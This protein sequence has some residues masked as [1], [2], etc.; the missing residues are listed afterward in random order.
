[1]KKN[2]LAV[3]TC[4]LTVLLASCGEDKAITAIKNARLSDFPQKTV[5]E[6]VAGFLADDTEWGVSRDPSG[7][8]TAVFCKGSYLDDGVPS[9]LSLSFSLDEKTGSFELTDM[10]ESGV[11]LPAGRSLATLCDIYGLS[12][13]EKN[14]LLFDA[15]EEEAKKLIDLGKEL[16]R[17]RDTDE[18]L[19]LYDELVRQ[20]AVVQDYNGAVDGNSLSAEQTKRAAEI[21]WDLSLL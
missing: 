16:K 18:Q 4:T 13:G 7:G 2:I 1:M 9:R 17:T 14:T 8:S 10:A 3:L 20:Q 21:L 11:S 5:G 19:R 12:E 6:A 15:F